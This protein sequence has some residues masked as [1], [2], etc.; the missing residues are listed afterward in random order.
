[1]IWPSRGTCAGA[2][3]GTPRKRLRDR[4]HGL[5]H[6]GHDMSDEDREIELDTDDLQRRMDG[7]MTNL[8][9]EF[10]VAAHRPGLASMLEPVQVEAYG[11]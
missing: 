1:M 11:R 4:G 10:A 5:R 6:L 3:R 9:T 2:R 7:A 8:R